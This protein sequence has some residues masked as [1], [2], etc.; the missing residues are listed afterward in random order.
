MR[1]AH[2]CS[3]SLR[4]QTKMA[5]I[6]EKENK[7]KKETKSKTKKVVVRGSVLA[8]DFLLEPWITEKSHEKSVENKYFF[9]VTK[10]A[11]KNNL[12]KAIEELY[13]TKVKSINIVNIPAKKK[14]RGRTT[15][16]KAGFKKAIVTLK[17]GSKIELFEA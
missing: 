14:M 7:S 9:K 2:F 4:S 1:D 8:Y 16:W 5:E 10:S 17:E 15:G 6:R 11:N 13:E 3:Y 12:K